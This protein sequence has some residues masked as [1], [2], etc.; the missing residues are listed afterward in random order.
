MISLNEEQI[1]RVLNEI[2]K[3]GVSSEALR[4]EV[5]DHACCSIEKQMTNGMSFEKSLE[6]SME[7]FGEKGLY[8]IENQIKSLKRKKGIMRKLRLSTTSIAACLTLLVLAVDAQERPE[9]KPL[10]E[11]KFRIS[12]SF[13]K[14]MDPFAKK[15]KFHSGLDMAVPSG[16]PVKAT[17]DGIVEKATN[18]EG[19]GN[20]IVIVHE[21]GFK[22]LYANLSE[23]KSEVGQKVKKGEIIALSGNTGRSTAPH[24][25]YEVMKDGEHVDPEM[26]FS[27]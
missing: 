15:E 3:Q 21:G 6:S 17:A 18:T 9:I 5:L 23:Y 24:L 19:Y 12:S 7:S 22:T 26:Y 10:E 25:H 2:E 20:H 8:K 4:T 27:E 14:R 11:G 13:G 16:T 1:E